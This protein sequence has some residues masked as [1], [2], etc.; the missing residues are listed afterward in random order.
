MGNEVGDDRIEHVSDT[1]NSPPSRYQT[2]LPSSESTDSTEQPKQRQRPP[3]I[4]DDPP[5]ASF[6]PFTNAYNSNNNGRL[7]VRSVTQR[8]I[9]LAIEELN[10]SDTRTKIKDHVISPLIKLIYSQM[11]PYLILAAIVLLAGLIMWVLMFTMFTL[12]Y[13]RK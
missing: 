8:L 1:E 9:A 12:S 4:R 10:Q 5:A 13:F 11:Y 7:V 6:T 3:L 2:H